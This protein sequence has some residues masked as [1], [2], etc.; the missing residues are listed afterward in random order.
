MLRNYSRETLRPFVRQAGSVRALSSEKAVAV[1][2]ESEVVVGK[3]KYDTREE[4]GRGYS[5]SVY[6]GVE[7]LRPHKRYAIKVIS[8][9]KFRADNRTLLEN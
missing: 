6:K 3:Y 7:I 5:S 1:V 2:K 9:S 4:L 8:L